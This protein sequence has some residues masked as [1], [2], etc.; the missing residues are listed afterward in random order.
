MLFYVLHAEMHI[1]LN[2]HKLICKANIIALLVGP[3]SCK[4]SI[5]FTYKLSTVRVLGQKTSRGHIY[6]LGTYIVVT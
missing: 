4:L 6:K 1:K 2:S 3:M 5:K